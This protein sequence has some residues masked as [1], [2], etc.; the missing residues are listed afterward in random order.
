[1]LEGNE[2][3]SGDLP[4]EI[5][6]DAAKRASLSEG[7]APFALVFGCSDS[8]AAAELIFDQGLGELFVVRTAGHVVDPGVLGSIEFGVEVL[9]AALIVVL[10]HDSCGAVV[11]T[12]NA[13]D[14]GELPGGYLRD[15]VERVLPSTLAVAAEDG[16]LSTDSVVA[17]HVLQTSRLLADRSQV[18]AR[19]IEE[20]TLA[21]VGATYQLAEGRV[22]AEGVIGEV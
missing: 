1:M 19:A 22:R 4:S 7:Q 14:S 10:G 21:I 17:E 16:E 13:V 9:G 2:R 3:F 8:R 11:A 5:S 20:G 18:L 6:H 12:M 15:I